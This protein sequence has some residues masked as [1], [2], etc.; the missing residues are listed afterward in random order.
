MRNRPQYSKSGFAVYLMAAL[1]F[2]LPATAQAASFNE[3]LDAYNRGDYQTAFQ[4]YKRLAEQGNPR[5]QNNLGNLYDMGQGVAP[6]LRQAA[7][8]YGKAAA[9]GHSIAQYNLGN[10]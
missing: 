1:L 8:W 5:A 10:M 7:Y 9:Q 3:G 4:I 2:V 6:D